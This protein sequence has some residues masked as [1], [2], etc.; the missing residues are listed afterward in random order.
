MYQPS[1]YRNRNIVDIPIRTLTNASFC[2]QEADSNRAGTL[3]NMIK[4]KKYKGVGD[5]HQ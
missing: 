1:N 4:L 3:V 2:M 5:K